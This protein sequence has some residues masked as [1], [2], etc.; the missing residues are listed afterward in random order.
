VKRNA[1]LKALKA[2]GCV[3]VKHGGKHDV[4]KNPQT[5]AVERI[6]RH[7]DIKEFLAKA[8]IHNLS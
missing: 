7:S 6:P 2:R 1:L 4:W 8:I 3:F 5:G